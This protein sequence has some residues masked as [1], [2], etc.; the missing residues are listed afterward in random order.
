MLRV[1]LLAFLV[2]LAL[3]A[4][5]G[6][7]SP[8]AATSTAAVADADDVPILTLDGTERSS[9]AT[10]SLDVGT[11]LA[12]QRR[13]AAA[14]L[15][16]HTLE[17][18]FRSNDSTDARQRLL[19]GT[20][21]AVENRVDALHDEER[22]LRAAYTNRSIDTTTLVRRLALLDA[23]AGELRATLDR[24]AAL[25]DEVPQFAIGGR[26]DRLDA[27]LIGFEGQVRDRTLSAI[28]GD[29]PAT[30]VYVD[31]SGGGVVL[32]TIDG[33][34]YVREVY[35]ADSR[36]AETADGVAF[37]EAV[38]LTGELYAPYAFNDSLTIGNNFF[39]PY[40]G[41]Y[42]LTI[43]MSQGTVVTYLDATTRR[44]FFEVQE[45]RLDFASSRAAVVGADNGTR[46]VVN[47]TFPGGPL[48]L[49]TSDNETGEPLAATV[50]VDGRTVRTGD[51]GVAWTLAPRGPVDVTAD[52]PRGNVT[53]SVRPLSPKQVHG[54][55]G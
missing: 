52:G 11:A 5:V 14:R 46:L 1:A 17:D 53:I 28:R 45:R 38:T 36:D 40:V 20:A 50:H 16:R 9:F 30:R 21:T 39:G 7:A 49:A 41:T 35:R 13:S 4:G 44:I 34:R 42:R 8:L 24:V 27:A 10:G 26:I 3:P 43:Q 22:E 12:D 54:G 55:D 47:R 33:G 37:G 23:R 32:A 6:G 2:V 51:D 18:R 15:E 25:A 48:R 19:L 29:G 31:A